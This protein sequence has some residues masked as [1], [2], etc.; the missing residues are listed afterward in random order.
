V[1]G[2]SEAELNKPHGDVQGWRVNLE[3]AAQPAGPPAEANPGDGHGREQQRE[4][5]SE[6]QKASPIGW[7][8]IRD[9]T[10]STVSNGAGTPTTYFRSRVRPTSVRYGPQ[11]DDGSAVVPGSPTARADLEQ[12]DIISAAVRVLA[13]HELDATDHCL[14]ST[15]G[16]RAKCVDQAHA[17]VGAVARAM[18][19]SR[20]PALTAPLPTSDAESGPGVAAQPFRGAAPGRSSVQRLWLRGSS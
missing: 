17:L 9:A 15:D 12:G 4:V 16:P 3:A 7:R 5:E 2:R 14:G 1:S 10:G 18:S 19:P 20:A 11:Q 6:D 8:M 13:V